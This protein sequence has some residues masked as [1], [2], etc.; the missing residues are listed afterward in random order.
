MAKKLAYIG[1]DGKVILLGSLDKYDEIIR[2]II[3]KKG[4][5]IYYGDEPP[6]QTDVFWVSNADMSE[7]IPDNTV[8]QNLYRR[9]AEIEAFLLKYR[10]VVD[11]GVIAGDSSIGGRTNIMATAEPVEPGTDVPGTGADDAVGTVAD[12]EQVIPEELGATVP[13]ISVKCDTAANFMENYQ[14][15]ISGELLWATD[16][17]KLFMYYD[18]VFIPVG[19]GGGGGG[20]GMNPDEIMSY[21]FD[22]LG[23]KAEDG[24]NY[25]IFV[26]TEGKLRNYRAE[27][28]ELE[29][30]HSADT[31]DTWVSGR[32]FINSIF[33]GGSGDAY[34]YQACSHNFVE[35]AN[36]SGHD[37]NLN[38]LY[39]LYAP[40]PDTAWKVLPLKGVI[41]DGTTFLIRGAQCSSKSNTTPIVVNEYDME[42]KDGSGLIKFEQDKP[43][44]Y[45]AWGDN[46]RF[47]NTSEEL[48]P[49]SQLSRVVYTTPMLKGYIDSVGI[50]T[51]SASEGSSPLSIATGD[52]WSDIVF[53]RYFT[54][55][56]VSQANKAYSARKSS[57]MWTYVNMAKEADE[58]L[59]NPR[60]YYDLPTKLKFTPR[61]DASG[62]NIFTTKTTF[63]AERPNMVN[64]TLGR[65]ATYKDADHKATRCFNWVSVG[66]HDEYLEVSRLSDYD[67]SEAIEIDSITDDSI[68]T[69]G[70]Y[71]GNPVVSTFIEQYRRI[72]W[73]AT[74]GVAVTTHKVLL[75]GLDAGE[76]KY[77]VRRRGDNDYRSDVL[78]FRVFADDEVS[79][80]EFVQVSDQQGF[81]W[82]EYQAWKKSALLISRDHPGI[83]FTINTGDITQNGNRENEWLD[84]YDGR[85]FLRSKEEMFTIGNN[86]LCGVKEYEL[87]DGTAGKYKIN[88]K[89][90]TFYYCFEL[91]LVNSAI[92]SSGTTEY[93]MPS[94]Y[95]FNF[96]QYHF[97]SIN[98][99]FAANTY[100][101]YQ[102]EAGTF[103]TDTYDQMAAWFRK[104]L[105]LW[106]GVASDVEPSGCGKCI[107]F[108]HEMPYTI[109]TRA[110]R[111]GS[112][113]RGGSK[114]NT[115]ATDG[116][117]YLWSRLFKQYGIR[118]V[119]GGHKHTYSMTWPVYDA[120]DGY[121]DESTHEVADG[122]DLM[123]SVSNAAS[124]RPVVQVTDAAA[125]KEGSGSARYE[126]VQK[127]TA[128]LYVMCQATGYKLVS[129]KELPCN[130][131]LE[132]LS[133]DWLKKC[134]PGTHPVDASGNV[135]DKANAE[136]YRPTYIHYSLGE[137]G[138]SITS[139]QVQYVYSEPNLQ[140]N[141]PGSFNIN[142]Q[143][144]RALSSLAID[145]GDYDIEF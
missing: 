139:Y 13:N 67:W 123:G 133:V 54:L 141:K 106:Q 46:E 76:Y 6:E 130:N 74:S 65:Q 40:N 98:S 11:Y 50:G 78:T 61:D 80:F 18:G 91:D 42:W 111:L 120:P 10:H 117:T 138:I 47:Y 70:Y 77:R 132:S 31:S 88:H 60:Y 108:C 105:Q 27:T 34:S 57:A 89:N 37:I 15:L 17:Q 2:E 131:R 43:T 101:C 129:N 53:V 137:D 26:D 94:L 100:K 35:L 9:L 86:D 102:Q 79:S 68:A 127:I 142:N 136:Q 125:I 19:S 72:R 36:C 73:V 83:A 8:V 84:Y 63:D 23:L 93:Y 85:Q 25:R 14:N 45:L 92:F 116:L 81:N 66:Y 115:F 97:V 39:L 90:I 114:L 144:T 3:A 143:Q 28:T 118:L 49:A 7:Y 99:E 71:A 110:T 12:D 128:P 62:K 51:G 22:Y 124:M 56:P 96:G 126:L 82:L 112:S 140:D 58:S 41:K 104:D 64:I 30:D 122:A 5:A 33:C 69:G 95:S 119:I 20:G 44:F 16:Q 107:V 24:H 21:F 109:I 113:G 135:T 38:G 52:S 75:F 55:D 134:F 32:L 48:V 1:K 145:G 103:T 4:N 29:K 121:I 87:G 59:S